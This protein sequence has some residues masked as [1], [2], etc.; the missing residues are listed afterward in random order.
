MKKIVESAEQ[1]DT[2]CDES[3]RP[4]LDTL[5]SL[6]RIALWITA[7]TI[8]IVGWLT[9]YRGFWHGFGSGACTMV[10]VL[11]VYHFA[12]WCNA[13]AQISGGTPHRACTGSTGGDT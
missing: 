8:Q 9:H 3:S 2:R 13:N 6:V 10:S 11:M 1:S 5:D 12:R 4:S 7:M